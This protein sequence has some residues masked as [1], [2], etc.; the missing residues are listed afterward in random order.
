MALD[1]LN[2]YLEALKDKD[3]PEIHELAQETGFGPHLPMEQIFGE[4]WLDKED[5]I[6]RE[7]GTPTLQCM[8]GVLQLRELRT[9]GIDYVVGGIDK[10]A[11]LLENSTLQRSFLMKGTTN[12]RTQLVGEILQSFPWDPDPRA[13]VHLE[14]VN[15]FPPIP[16]LATTAYAY[17]IAYS[18]VRDRV[19]RLLHPN[20]CTRYGKNAIKALYAEAQKALTA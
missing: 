9:G 5:Q 2:H 20:T 17:K 13:T 12:A 16:G 15:A 3:W 6:N 4:N 10:R 11:T 18:Y 1:T 7:G 14:V 8:R 19:N